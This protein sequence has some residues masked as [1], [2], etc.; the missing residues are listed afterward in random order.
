MNLNIIIP[1]VSG[2]LIAIANFYVKN[3]MNQISSFSIPNLILNAT[4]IFSVGIGIVGGLLMW[5]S[6]KILPLWIVIL[7]I[8]TIS[9]VGSILLGVIILKESI[10]PIRSIL[11]VFIVTLLIVL[12]RIK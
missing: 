1:F 12:M 11:M 6:L 7:I 8:N 9:T 2:I 10:S 5:Y 4:L 3:A